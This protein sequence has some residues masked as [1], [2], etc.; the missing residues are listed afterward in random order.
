MIKNRKAFTL[1]EFLVVVAIFM[2]VIGIATEAFLSL[3]KDYKVLMSYLSSYLKGRESIDIISRDCRMAIRIM[4]YYTGYVTTNSCLVLKVPSI[5]MSGNIIDVNHKF[6]YII[7]R[8]NNGDL[9]KTVMPGPNSARLAYD[10]VL[11]KSV[12]SIY[13]ARDGIGLSSIT[14]KSSITHLTIWVSI[15]QTIL[16]KDYRVNPGT[17]MKL[18]NY[19]WE[20]VR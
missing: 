13:I 7:Y 16:G 2:L 4:D 15:V 10:N 20:H 19:E 8:I 11:K 5:D 9:W 14:H 3:N 6:D 17:T 18:M 12:E 1:T